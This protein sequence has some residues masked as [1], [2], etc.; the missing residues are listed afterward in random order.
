[1]LSR[2]IKFRYL[3]VIKTKKKGD[4]FLLHRFTSQE[5]G[6]SL[7]RRRFCYPREGFTPRLE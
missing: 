1:M 6:R 3:I 2:V 5:M 7:V 4:N